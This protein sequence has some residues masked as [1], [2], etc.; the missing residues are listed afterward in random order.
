MSGPVVEGVIGHHAKLKDWPDTKGRNQI[1]A[2]VL[3]EPHTDGVRFGGEILHRMRGASILR[4]LAAELLRVPEMNAR[5]IADFH[6]DRQMREGWRGAADD[7]VLSFVGKVRP[8]KIEEVDIV[9]AVARLAA[10]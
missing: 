1:E 10:R 2:I 4:T 9:D 7:G 5:L 3:T 6:L 8:V